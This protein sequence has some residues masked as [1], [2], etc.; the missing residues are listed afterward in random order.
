MCSSSWSALAHTRE[1]ERRRE[2]EAAEREIQTKDR[3][4]EI[5]RQKA[6]K[7]TNIEKLNNRMT[8]DFVNRLG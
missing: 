6:P 4:G 8:L 7:E 3:G 5:G 2:R 1:A